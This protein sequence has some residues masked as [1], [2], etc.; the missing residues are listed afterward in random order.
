MVSRLLK[1]GSQSQRHEAFSDSNHE[2]PAYAARGAAIEGFVKG[3]DPEFPPADVSFR[4][5]EKAEKPL[6][7]AIQKTKNRKDY[8]G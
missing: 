1:A 5:V 6:N 8:E 4:K 7:P 3:N 2:Q